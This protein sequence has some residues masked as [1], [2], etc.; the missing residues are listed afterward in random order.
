MHRLIDEEIENE[1][2]DSRHIILG[3]FSQGGTL[4]QWAAF[5]Y[6]KPLGALVAL[7]TYV[8][9]PESIEKVHDET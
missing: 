3:G 7:S 6:P 1:G 4:A 8:P 5:T 2:I 9:L